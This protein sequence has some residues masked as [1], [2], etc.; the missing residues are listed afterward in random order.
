MDVSSLKEFLQ[1]FVDSIKQDV[2]DTFYAAEFTGDKIKSVYKMQTA[3]SITGIKK[4][5]MAEKLSQ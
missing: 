1:Y 3:L 5:S 4:R 2:T